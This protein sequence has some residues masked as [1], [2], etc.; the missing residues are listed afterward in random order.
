MRQDTLATL[1]TLDS[2]VASLLN[3]CQLLE[4]KLRKLCGNA[5]PDYHVVVMCRRLVSS[6][7]ANTRQKFP[8]YLHNSLNLEERD[9]DQVWQPVHPPDALHAANVMDVFT[10]FASTLD[11]FARMVR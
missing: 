4:D 9:R 6:W 2:D 5:L 11:V 3:S 8:E 10:M 1:P 7:V